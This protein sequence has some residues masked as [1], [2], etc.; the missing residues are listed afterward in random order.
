MNLRNMNYA[1]GDQVGRV[2]A[3]NMR[4]LPNVTQKVVINMGNGKIAQDEFEFLNNFRKRRHKLKS[5]M[6]WVGL[7]ELKTE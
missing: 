3:V 2:Y 4:L 5:E 6:W 1:K 7:K